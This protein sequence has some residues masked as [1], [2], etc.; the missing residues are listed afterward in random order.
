MPHDPPP[1]K[2]T[3]ADMFHT[4]ADP[5]SWMTPIDPPP[6]RVGRRPRWWVT[7]LVFWGLA[8][9]IAVA[10]AWGGFLRWGFLPP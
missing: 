7:H 4:G 2:P 5:L 8:V 9:P 3:G 10:L 6:L 1:R